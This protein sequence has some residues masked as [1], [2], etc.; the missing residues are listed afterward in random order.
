MR[1]FFFAGPV[2]V[3]QPGSSSPSARNSESE[4]E[5]T[6]F[7]CWFAFFWNCALYSSHGKSVPMKPHSVSLPSGCSCA[8]SID[9]E[10]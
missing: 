1:V 8:G 9:T 4:V 3:N 7:F 5:I 10:N 6:A 2:S